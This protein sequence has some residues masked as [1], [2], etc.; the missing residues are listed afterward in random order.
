[1]AFVPIANACSAE[2]RLS[3]GGVR[4]ALTLGFYR[5]DGWTAATLQ[6]LADLLSEWWFNQLRTHQT[7]NVSM[8]EVYVR[9]LTTESSPVAT[10]V[11]RAGTTGTW[12]GTPKLPQNTAYCISFRTALRGRANRGRNYVPVGSSDYVSTAGSINGSTRDAWLADYRTLL[13]GGAY[14]PTPARWVVLSRQLNG[15]IQGRAVPI[16]AVV[17]ADNYMDSQR[18]RLPGRGYT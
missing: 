4:I 2:L 1:M 13:P 12:A 3:W 10:S 15:V 16:T 14:D 6:T 17:A 18:K 8:R 5:S 7:N 11:T 9:D